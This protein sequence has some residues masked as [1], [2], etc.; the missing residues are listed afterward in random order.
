MLRESCFDGRSRATAGKLKRMESLSIVPTFQCLT[1][2]SQRHIERQVSCCTNHWS[3]SAS[4]TILLKSLS[5]FSGT[6]SNMTLLSF[7]PRLITLSMS[8]LLSCIALKA[9]WSLEGVA[10]KVSSDALGPDRNGSGLVR[11]S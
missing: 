8:C 5:T 7:T 10:S 2:R 11:W 6:L 1:R 9:V 4:S 3:I